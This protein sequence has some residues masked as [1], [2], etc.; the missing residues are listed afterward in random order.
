MKG[1]WITIFCLGVGVTTTYSQVEIQ[2]QKCLGG[3]SNDFGY[4]IQQTF[5]GGYVVAGSSNSTNGV[6]SGNHGV[7]DFWVVKLDAGGNLQWQKCLGGTGTDFANSIQQTSDGGYVVAGCTQSIDGDVSGNH[8]G[9]DSW[10]VKLDAGGNLQWH[11]CLGGTGTDYAYS[12]QQTSDGGYVVAGYTFSTDGD[13]SGNHGVG[14]FWVVK[15][16]AGGNLQWQKCLGGTGA[17]NAISIQE[18]SDGGYVVAG[19]THSIDGDVSG[20][21]GGYDSWVVKLDA[22]GNLQWQKCL[23][24]TGN[25]WTHSIQE[26]SDGGY[27]VAGSTYS[28]DGDVSGNHGGGDFWVV[29]LDAGGNLQWQKCLGGTNY[30]FANSI[31]QTSDEGYVVAGFSESANGDVSGNHGGY[32]SWVVKLDAGGNLQWQKCLGGSNEDWARSIQQTSD[33]GYVVAGWAESTDGDVSGNH[34]DSDFWVVKLFVPNISGI[35]F[36]DENLNGINDSSEPVVA[37]HLVKLEPGPHYTYTNNDGYYYFRADTGNYTVSYIQQP[38]WYAT[39]PIHNFSLD[40]VGHVIDTLDIGV[41]TRTS[42]N[43]VA[44]YITGSPTRVGFETKYWL[45]Y[46]NWGTVNASGTVNFEYDSLLTYLS[47][48]ETPVSHTGNN[49]VF[50]YNTLGPGVQRTI[51]ADFQVPGVQH[52]GDTLHS[53]AMITPLIPDTFVTNNYDT[54]MQVIT[55][56]YDP[57][58]KTVSP[59]GYEQWGFVEHGQRLTYTIRFQNT[60]TDTAFTVV[61]RDT[62]DT[63]LDIETFVVEANSHNVTWQLHSGNELFFT[64]QNILLPDSNVNEPESHGF[65]RY[66]ISP[67]QGLAD[68]T[69]ATNTSY[70]FFDYNPAIV[71]NTTLN[72]FVTNIP[73]AKPIMEVLKTLVFPNPSN[74][75]VYINL[76]EFTRKVEVY[77]S[78]GSLVQQLVPQKQVAEINA[79]EL[80]KGVYVVKIYSGKGVVTTRFVKE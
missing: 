43:D 25:D 40:S 9:Y 52:F 48:T 80:A 79:R 44:V 63:D 15:L 8:G 75:V 70:I 67:K 29:K 76:P 61:I 4:S 69:T 46:K 55:G 19:N 72:T 62:L 14:D 31:Q 12:I 57:N 39:T 50:D 56:S 74:D 77:N 42:V 30:D 16:D 33:G 2:W 34:G 26:T 78:A 6:A 21:H 22:G 38:Y 47:S 45:T 58:D 68:G 32:D 54:L 7:E 13:V 3:S 17:D 65:I 5:D 36:L 11:K 51:R 37:G 41:Y 28:T 35:M 66:S 20:N 71:T 64:F 27:V 10:V 24:G 23:G 59:A 18:T 53:Y 60:G 1:I 73:V 49:L